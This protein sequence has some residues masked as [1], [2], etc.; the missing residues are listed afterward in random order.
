MG[1]ALSAHLGLYDFNTAFLTNNASVFHA[2]VFTTV[3]LIVFGG[4]ENLCTEKTIALR[5]KG[6]IINGFRFFNLSMGP[7][8]NLL[9]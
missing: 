6:T 8:P 3:T 7:F 2:F 5:F 4:T 9:R 1:H